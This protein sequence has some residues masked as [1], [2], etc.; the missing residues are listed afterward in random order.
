MIHHY[1]NAKLAGTLPLKVGVKGEVSASS[2]KLL[3]M[4]FEIYS[5]I[6]QINSQ[7]GKITF[8]MLAARINSFMYHNYKQDMLQ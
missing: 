4:A 3:C 6:F 2:F 7:E 8:K 5:W 1:V